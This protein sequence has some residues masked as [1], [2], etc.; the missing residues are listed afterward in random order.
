MQKNP[1][2]ENSGSDRNESPFHFRGNARY[3]T[4]LTG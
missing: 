2:S 1:R 3:V 4:D